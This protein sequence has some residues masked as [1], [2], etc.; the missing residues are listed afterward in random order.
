M[1]TAGIRKY[2]ICKFKGYKLQ[3][4]FVL[5]SFFFGGWKKGMNQLV[6]VDT[7]AFNLNIR[8]EAFLRITMATRI[9]FGQSITLLFLK[10]RQTLCTHGN[11]IVKDLPR[12]LWISWRRMESCE[13]VQL[14]S[15][16]KVV[17]HIQSISFLRSTFF[18]NIYEKY[19][20]KE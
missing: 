1:K 7:S 11:V 20:R 4:K 12:R 14:S 6:R 3:T 18:R 10:L 13:V 5:Q 17:P 19:L 8:Q 2:S 16:L 9:T 15:P